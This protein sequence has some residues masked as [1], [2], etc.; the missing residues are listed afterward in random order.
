MTAFRQHELITVSDALD[1]A[2]DATGNY[3][4]F[5]V[6]Q[7]KKHGYDVKTLSSLSGREINN[8][9]LAV[10]SKGNRALNKFEPRTKGRDF[11]FIC[12][13]DHLILRALERDGN[14]SLLPLLLYVF[15]HELVHIVRFCNFFQ[16]FDV[17]DRKRAEEEEVVH[18]MTFDIL[19]NFSLSKLD[20]VLDSYQGHRMCQIASQ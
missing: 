10:L 1:I 7:W 14:L 20:Y 11:Y 15:T 3:F 17:T 19:K 12:L 4:K 5:S 13:Q 16:R 8:F 2:E 9:A 18:S 6:G